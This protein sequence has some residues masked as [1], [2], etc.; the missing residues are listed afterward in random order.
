[1]RVFRYA[2]VVLVPLKDDPIFAMTI[3]GKLKSD[4]AAG[5]P[6][7]AILNGGGAEIVEGAGLS[8]PAR[9]MGRRRAVSGEQY[10]RCA[11]ISRL[12][13]RFENLSAVGKGQG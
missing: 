2:Y 11:L 5:A 7:L 8:C 1:M 6:V 12:L 4:L 10:D 3:L 13:S 9:G